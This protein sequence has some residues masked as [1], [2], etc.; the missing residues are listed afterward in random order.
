MFFMPQIF[1]PIWPW[2]LTPLTARVIG[3]WFSLPGAGG[4][5][6]AR[7]KRWSAVRITMQGTLI[8]VGLLLIGVW[9]AWSDFDT[10]KPLTWAYLGMLTVSF[11]GIGFLYFWMGRQK[12]T[13]SS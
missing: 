5:M 9:R 6:I 3:G 10:A 12:Q 11:I 2:T 13:A 7:E 8:Y 4:L 1:I